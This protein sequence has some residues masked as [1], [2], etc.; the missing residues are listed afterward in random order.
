MFCFPR[1]HLRSIFLPSASPL[2]T[3]DNGAPDLFHILELQTG[4]HFRSSHLSPFF[5]SSSGHIFSGLAGTTLVFLTF[6][7]FSILF[8]TTTLRCVTNKNRLFNQV[9]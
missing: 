4:S 8:C 1:L 3:T 6:H 7:L 5:V 2:S 9:L